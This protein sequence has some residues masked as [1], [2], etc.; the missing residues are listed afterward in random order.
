[1]NN[2]VD[3][4]VIIVTGAAGGFGKVLSGKAAQLGGRM[5][6]ADINT[7]ALQD[8]VQEIVNTGGT[9]LAMEADVTK[10]DSMHQ[11][12]DQA[13]DAYGQVDVLINN[14]GIM[15]LAFFSDHQQASAAWD[16]CIDI[17][18]KGVLNG[19]TAVYD[20]MV[21]NGQG[22]IVN[23]SSIYGKYPSAGGAVYGATK[24]AVDFLSESLRQESPGKIKVTT[25]R[26]AAAGGTGLVDTVIN[27]AACT[28]LMGA[29]AGPYMEMIMAAADG[30]LSQVKTDIANPEYF[31]L[32]P[33]EIADQILY[34]VNQPWGL[35]LG[36]ITIRA[37][38]ELS[39]I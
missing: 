19:I 34:A 7:D 15:P 6:C 21:A 30:K 31:L 1:M 26:P 17:N 23:I 28:G 35:S 32:G 25:V 8:S 18:F 29:N 4:K 39:V 2:Y 14:A 37:T 3:G 12:V 27:P 22:H 38:G 11:L 9:A 5:V 13:L 24:A 33:D 10:T 36:E 16:R 20:H